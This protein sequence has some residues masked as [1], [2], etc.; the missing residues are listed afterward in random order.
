M[1][2]LQIEGWIVMLHPFLLCLG[3]R[4]RG[5]AFRHPRFTAHR[6]RLISLTGR[7][8]SRSTYPNK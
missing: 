7:E 5:H 4:A 2:M 3:R 1:T 8:E 6:P